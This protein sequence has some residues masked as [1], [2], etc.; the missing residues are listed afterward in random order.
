MAIRSSSAPTSDPGSAIR[1]AGSSRPSRGATQALGWPQ[2]RAANELLG[3]DADTI[4][5][6]W[7]GRP[8]DY[9]RVVDALVVVD[10]LT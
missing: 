6:G 3:I 2:I 1:A 8:V 5:C 4:A 7:D 9:G 10:G